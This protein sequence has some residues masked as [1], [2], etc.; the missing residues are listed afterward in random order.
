MYDLGQASAML[1]LQAAELG[2]ST[3]QMGGYDREKARAA[4]GIPEQYQMGIAIA[5][6]YQGEPALLPAER[7]QQM[8][9]SPRTRKDLNEFVFSGW[10]EALHLK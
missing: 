6:G 3:H 2:L 7:L 9:T 5:L 4:L 1:V 10:G 8:E